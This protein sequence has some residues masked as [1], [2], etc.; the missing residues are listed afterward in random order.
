M[1]AIVLVL[2]FGGGKDATASAPETQ[3]ATTDR[4]APVEN[5]KS[6]VK[7][8]DAGKFALPKL[9]GGTPIRIRDPFSISI[10]PSPNE[11]SGEGAAAQE[12]PTREEQLR[13]IEFSGVC[14]VGDDR[15]ALVDGRYVRSGDAVRGFTVKKIEQE[16]LLLEDDLGVVSIRFGKGFTP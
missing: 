14:L 12:E 6:I 9:P 11:E 8:I 15:L 13:A 3:E 1:L 5:L 16:S 10:F 2:R 7:R 4:H